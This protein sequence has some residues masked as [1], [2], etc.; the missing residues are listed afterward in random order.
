MDNKKIYRDESLWDKIKRFLKWLFNLLFG[1]FLR[2][3]EDKDKTNNIVHNRLENSNYNSSGNTTS[4]EEKKKDTK[5]KDVEKNKV[6]EMPQINNKV[7]APVIEDRK[8][9]GNDINNLFEI[10]NSPS[11][12]VEPKIIEANGKI[13]NFYKK[14]NEIKYVSPNEKEASY[15]VDDKEIVTK[16]F[17][18]YGMVEAAGYLMKK[19]RDKKMDKL[20]STTIE[21]DK[22]DEVSKGPIVNKETKK[23]MGQY[24]KKE[25]KLKNGNR[26]IEEKKILLDEKGNKQSIEET[27]LLN[28]E[29]YTYTKVLNGKTVFQSVKDE[30]GTIIKSYDEK[31]NV[32]DTFKYDKNGMPIEKVN[33]VGSDGNIKKVPKTYPG[34]D[35]IPEDKKDN[36]KGTKANNEYSKY[37]KVLKY[38]GLPQNVKELVDISY[39]KY[40]HNYE[41]KDFQE[42][43]DVLEHNKHR[44]RH[45]GISRGR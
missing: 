28:D 7:I 22:A 17:L 27:Y 45:K 40:I 33:I 43:K 8:A 9:I 44:D 15:K 21:G 1:R 5:K 37:L 11:T 10:D 34:I 30:K 16:T 42:A 39:K 13:V 35:N 6:E 36:L 4:S 32:K 38:A 29:S 41:I 12:D 25:T 19:V 2:K 20:I 23:F 26:S 24:K 31:G 18:V 3:K 14:D